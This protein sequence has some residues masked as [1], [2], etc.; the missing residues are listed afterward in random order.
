ML[1][2]QS[3]SGVFPLKFFMVVG[4]LYS[5]RRRAMVSWS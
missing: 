5:K 4:A 1:A 2:V 3:W